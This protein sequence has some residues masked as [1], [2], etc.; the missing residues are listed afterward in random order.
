MEDIL[1]EFV[2]DAKRSEL[3]AE[4]DARAKKRQKIA[5]IVMN[6]FRSKAKLNPKIS[7]VVKDLNG[8][9][10]KIDNGMHS[11]GLTN[12]ALKLE[13][14]S[15]KV[16]AKRLPESSLLED[17]VLGRDSDKQAILQRLLEDGA[18]LEQDFVI[19][20]VGMG[21]IGKTTLARLIYNDEK[22]EGKFDLKAWVCVADVFDVPKITRTILEQVT[23]RKCDLDDFDSLQK[24][25]KGK[26]SG[27]KFFLILDDVWNK[28]YGNWDKLKR[29]FMSGALGSK[30]IVTTQNKDVGMMIKGDDQ[31]YNLELLQDD[32]CLP[33]FTQHA[34]GK[35][36][37]DAHLNLQD[38]GEKLVERC[39]RL[40]LALKHWVASCGESCVVM[41]GRIY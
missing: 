4:S 36:N 22:L 6:L 28:E 8:R 19:P 12:W 26:L 9:L 29:P 38:V 13:D 11:L 10:Q 2:I 15:H 20:I 3:I 30:I 7:S 40:P 35:E 39:K 21:G 14:K 25:L 5:S 17:M 32:A 24:E 31:V 27:R 37:F 16:A 23:R 41:S 18:S 1:K 34:L 33:L